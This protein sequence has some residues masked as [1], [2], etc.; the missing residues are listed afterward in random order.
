MMGF[1]GIVALYQAIGIIL[2][3]QY[4]SPVYYL[5][6]GDF[7]NYKEVLGTMFSPE[8]INIALSKT[9]VENRDPDSIRISDKT[10]LKQLL[11]NKVY[12]KMFR[13]GAVLA[14]LRQFS[15][16]NAILFYSTSI[17]KTIGLEVKLTRLI[18]FFI[19]LSMGFSS[20]FA[21]LLLKYIGRKSALV[22]GQAFLAVDLFLVG[23]ISNVSPEST[24]ALASIVCIYF[25]F[26]TYSLNATLWAYVA[27]IQ[28][29][30]AISITTGVNFF[31]NVVILVI[32]PYAVENAGVSAVFYFFA[33]CMAFGSVYCAI[34]VIETKHRSIEEIELEMFTLAIKDEEDDNE[35]Q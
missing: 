4:D 3:F 33:G 35:E 31:F 11:C 27:E 23:I 20:L 25:I 8:D 9:K 13:I 17:F 28:N 29:E 7:D 21:V 10:T 19:G 34:D 26:F 16:I 12:R 32:F 14:T 1:S 24:A 5:Q 22:S 6:I 18:T 15:G 30:T 2:F